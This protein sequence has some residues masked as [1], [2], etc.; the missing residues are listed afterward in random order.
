MLE[1]NVA[2]RVCIDRVGYL[3][4]PRGNEQA[5]IAP[6][7]NLHDLKKY[8][9]QVPDS[10]QE[11]LSRDWNPVLGIWAERH[12]WSHGDLKVSRGHHVESL[13]AI[14]TNGNGKAYFMS[15][16]SYGLSYYDQFFIDFPRRALPVQRPPASTNTV[17]RVVGA[18]LSLDWNNISDSLRQEYNK[19][20]NPYYRQV[21]LGKFMQFHSDVW[22]RRHFWTWTNALT[23]AY[24][25]SASIQHFTEASWVVPFKWVVGG[26]N[27]IQEHYWIRVEGKPTK[28][29]RHGSKMVSQSD[30]LADFYDNKWQIPSPQT[31]QATWDTINQ[32]KKPPFSPLPEFGAVDSEPDQEETIFQM[33][34]D[35]QLMT[36]SD[37]IMEDWERQDVDWSVKRPSLTLTDLPSLIRLKILK[38]VL[39]SEKPIKPRRCDRVIGKNFK[40]M[41]DKHCPCRVCRGMQLERWDI[42]WIRSTFAV[43][44]TCRT[45]REESIPIYYTHNKFQFYVGNQNTQTMALILQNFFLIIGRETARYIQHIIWEDVNDPR[46]F[47]EVLAMH[48][49]R[50]LSGVKTI[51]FVR[52][53][54]KTKECRRVPPSSQKEASP[55]FL[56]MKHFLD[57]RYLLRNSCTKIDIVFPKVPAA[58]P[59][60]NAVHDVNCKQ[61]RRHRIFFKKIEKWFFRM[62]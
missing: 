4:K 6:P 50:E 48:T 32:I 53:P 60:T 59:N 46:A 2:D 61:C 5:S 1:Y 21:I 28:H 36:I 38:M 9:L 56:A 25:D 17:H 14:S 54:T 49:M 7:D 30:Q 42:R 41:I 8:L 37:V 44:A 10:E 27:V 26:E 62:Q 51:K 19:I 33:E 43:A 24:H 20:G 13:H 45:L 29:G 39:I 3:I 40:P 31:R 52:L 35:Q 58:I 34:L 15:G 22:A 55:A 16:S 57:T 47:E 18:S 11:R 12:G 23:R